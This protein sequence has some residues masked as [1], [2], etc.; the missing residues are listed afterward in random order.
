MRE[1]RSSTRCA[2]VRSGFLYVSSE[3]V[4]WA[5]SEALSSR[6]TSAKQL[7]VFMS[8]RRQQQKL[9]GPQM[10]VCELKKLVPIK[11]GDCVFSIAI[12]KSDSA[13]NGLIQRRHLI[14]A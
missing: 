3:V 1:I 11:I 4:C 14:C 6:V 9:M 5:K 8:S 2:T 10:H 7:L 13:H 12:M